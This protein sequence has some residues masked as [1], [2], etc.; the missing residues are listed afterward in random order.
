MAAE[1]SASTP[2]SLREAYVAKLEGLP[3]GQGNASSWLSGDLYVNT[4]HDFSLRVPPGWTAELRGSDLYLHGPGGRDRAEMV[5]ESLARTGVSG[6]VARNYARQAAREGLEAAGP[7]TKATLPAGEAAILPLR[8][9]D[10]SGKPVLIRKMFLVRFDRAYVLSFRI[11]EDK[12]EETDQTFMKLT[13]SIVFLSPDRRE[14]LQAPRITL[15]R[16]GGGD[17]WNSLAARASGAPLAGAA[18]AG[19]SA[20]DAAGQAGSEAA[21][22]GDAHGLAA[23]N[24]LDAG[25]PPKA[26]LLLKLAPASALE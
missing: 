26:G 16:A 4:R 15:H 12:A 2:E 21:A 8:S 10:A 18:G 17:T 20:A 24:G 13:G 9:T 14:A 25:Q 1:V 11:P 3:A 5:V 6:E 19:T 23:F 22:S 7:L